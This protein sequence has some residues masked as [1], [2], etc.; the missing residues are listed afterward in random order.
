[1]YALALEHDISFEQTPL[2]RLLGYYVQ[3]RRSTRLVGQRPR[4]LVT[5]RL[6]GLAL[7]V[8]LTKLPVTKAAGLGFGEL[9]G[10]FAQL[11]SLATTTDSLYL[12][13]SKQ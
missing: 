9:F 10:Q 12:S 5:K 4:Q 8:A 6:A 1:M 11:A 7:P 2:A 3:L 13:R